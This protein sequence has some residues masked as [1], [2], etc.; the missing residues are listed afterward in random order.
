MVVKKLPWPFDV[1]IALESL[2]ARLKLARRR[3]RITVK[4]LSQRIGVSPS[5]VARLEE[6]DPRVAAGHYFSALWLFGLLQ[7]VER[8]ADATR[9]SVAL[10]HDLANVPRRGRSK[11]SPHA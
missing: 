6:G 4:E 9:D 10:E 8:L 3:R 2:G 11:G 5:T 1:R 7:D